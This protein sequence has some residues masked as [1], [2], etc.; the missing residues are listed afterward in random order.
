MGQLF[1]FLYKYRAFFTFLTLELLCIWMIVRNNNYQRA[2]YFS[3]AS[4]FV[5]N[6][7]ERTNNISDYFSL[8]KVNR[9]LAE[10]N[11]RLRELL[12]EAT[13]ISL[14]SLGV[15]EI[16]A[17]TTDS[18]QYQLIAAEIV[19]NSIRQSHNFFRINKG[20]KD[21]IKPG[22]GV[23]NQKGVVGKIRAVSKNY[24]T[25]IS[26]LNSQNQVSAKHKNSNRYATVQWDGDGRDPRIAKLL[27]VTRE[28][29]INVGDT[30]LTSSFN[31][32]YPK[33]IMIGTVAS[34]KPDQNQRD[35][36]ID[37]ALSVDF[38]SLAYVY[39]IKNLLIPEE[40]SLFQNDPIDFNE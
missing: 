24:A 8:N 18:I 25:G 12:I 27:Y 29:D 36:E 32:V 6:I 2:A 31:A 11:A 30:I 20:G 15:F 13:K 38:G 22:M 4:G 16:D 7:N 21:G 19:D 14:D 9:E 34:V 5:G 10:E 37:I 3:A 1:A 23:I 17:D 35:L 39:V 28:V 40:D 26:L 33:D